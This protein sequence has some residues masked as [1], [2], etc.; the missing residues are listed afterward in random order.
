MAADGNRIGARKK[1]LIVSINYRPELTG[2]GKFTAEM[3]E[4][5]AGKGVEVR[6]ITAPPY[7]PAW[8]VVTGY[9][10][11]RYKREHL[12][13]VRVLRCPLWVPARPNGLRRILH[14]FSFALSSC[15]PTICSGLSWRPEWIVVLEPPLICLPAALLASKLSGARSW[16]HIQDFEVDA[17]FGLGLLKSRGLH[18]FVTQIERWLMRRCDRVSTISDRMLERLDAKGVSPTARFLFPNWVDTDLIRPISDAGRLRAEF[19]IPEDQIV[20]LYSGN[21]GQKQGLDLII[22]VARLF[23]G[24]ADFLFILCG[25]GAARRELEA[26]A[27][28]LSNVRFLPLQPLERFNELLN[29]ADIHLL[30]QR[31]DAEDL[32]MP[33]KLAAMLASSRPVIA[34]ARAGSQVAEVVNGCGLVVNPGDQKALLSAVE[35]LGYSPGE[36]QRLGAAGRIFAV[37]H[38]SKHG[39]LSRLLD[40]LDLNRC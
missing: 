12:D 31:I 19:G 13:G 8:R 32:V 20:L 39:V 34:T 23:S 30:P 33:S 7:Y 15:L 27:A 40:E 26:Q 37:E 9:S 38:W 10:G 21:M 14:L 6:V 29:L 16:L 11:T 35:R 22:E 5:V 18:R 28:S 24:T 2:I 36:C 17:A 1:L 25:D 3:A 4:W